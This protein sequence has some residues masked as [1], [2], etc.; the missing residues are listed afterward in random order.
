[1]YVALLNAGVPVESPEIQQRSSSCVR[2]PS[3]TYVVSLQTMAARA[4]EPK[5]DKLLIQQLARWLEAAQRKEARDRGGWYYGDTPASTDN[6]NSQ[7]AMLA[8]S[9]AERVGVRVNEVT[10]RVAQAYWRKGQNN[11]GS[12]SYKVDGSG[13]GSGSMTCA[14]IT[15]MVISADRLARPMPR[16]TVTRS[17]VVA[18]VPRTTRSNGR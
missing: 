3:K 11:D 4:A 2:P 6:S 13:G 15:S 14:G 12:W 8:L 16:S 1:M 10:W 7:F 18:V 9:E 17:I 5:K